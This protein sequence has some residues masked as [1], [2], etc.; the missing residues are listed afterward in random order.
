MKAGITSFLFILSAYLTT[1]QTWQLLPNSPTAALV[2]D[3]IYFVNENKGWL[4]NL[5]G[6]IFKTEDGGITFDTL[7]IQ[8]GTAFRSL[9]F[10]DSLHGFAGNL[11]PGSWISGVTDTIPL[12][13][14]IDGG[15]SWQPVTNINITGQY[16]KGICGINVVNDTLIYAVGRY[17][18]PPVFLKTIDGG[19]TWNSTDCSAFAGLL[20]D[21]HFFSPDTGIVVGGNDSGYAAVFYTVNGGMTWQQVALHSHF[22]SYHWKISFP[23]RNIGYVTVSS[24][25]STNQIIKTTDGGLTWQNFSLPAPANADFTGIGFINDSVGWAGAW[26]PGVNYVTYD[27]GNTWS[28]FTLDP[29]FNRFRKINDTTAFICGERVW[30][31]TTQSVGISEIPNQ[32]IGYMLK[33]NFPNPFTEN[34]FIEY[35]IPESGLVELVLFDGGGRTLK[36]LVNQSQSKGTYTVEINLPYKY[37]TLFYCKLSVNGFKKIIQ[38]VMLKQ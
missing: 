30:K 32:Y 18:G 14:T 15:N 36:T 25:G 10:I 33:Q 34:T 35:S 2:N 4:V 38:M 9:G 1:A 22:P 16:P 5:N 12:Y 37:N 19:Q 13:E 8:P 31:Y 21:V 28:P 20:I 26:Y 27:G 7:L 11:G 24:A 6:Y 3:D 17:A 29:A 23:S